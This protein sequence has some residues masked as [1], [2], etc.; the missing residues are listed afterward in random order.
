MEVTYYGH[1]AVKVKSDVNMVFDPWV[2]GNPKFKGDPRDI[3]DVDLV[4]VS[5]DH[6][7]HGFS[8]AVE[9][10]K[11]TGAS[12]VGI[13]ELA[14]KAESM[15]VRSA[16]GGNIGGPIRVKGIEVILTPAA[17]SCSAGSPVGFVV[18]TSEGA[19]YHA[20]DTGLLYEMKLIGELYKPK[21]AFLPVGGFYTMGVREAAKAVELIAP[22]KVV[23]IHWGTFPVLEETPDR[24]VKEVKKLKVDTEVVVLNPGEKTEI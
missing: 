9:I 23:P 15:G 7:D 4:L 12:L 20:G 6:A 24:F 3:E 16:I 5:H 1:A 8:D 11:K 10:C 2:K 14:S 22:E 13:F 17:H 21:V 18:L 19:I